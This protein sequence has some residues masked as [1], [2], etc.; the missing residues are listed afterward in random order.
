[1]LKRSYRVV[2]IKT[3]AARYGLFL[4]K[5]STL[6]IFPFNSGISP[7]NI[8]IEIRHIFC[9]IKIERAGQKNALTFRK[10]NN[11]VYILLFKLTNIIANWNEYKLPGQK[12]KNSARPP[13]C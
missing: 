2:R 13:T 10:Y 12:N 5:P 1:M 3:N 8:K 9:S 4:I 6:F 7:L 11:T